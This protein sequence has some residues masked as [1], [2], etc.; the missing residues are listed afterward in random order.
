MFKKIL[1]SV[2]LLV[3][4]LCFAHKEKW[5]DNK[6]DWTPLMFAIYNGQTENFISIINAGAD[7]NYKIKT[8]FKL[9]AMHV[10]V[11]KN[12]DIAVNHL[13]ATRK[14]KNIQTYFE[15]SCGMNNIKTVEL[16]IKNGAHVNSPNGTFSNLMEACA[17]GS[18]EIVECLLKSGAKVNNYREVDG[19]T[20]LMLAALNG[21]PK[22]VKLLLK[23][24]A[25]KFQK[26]KNG[27]IAI[28]YVDQIYA[29]S[30]VSDTVKDELKVLLK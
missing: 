17:R 18:S 28:N 15:L 24:K 10:A 19:I 7:V 2:L 21:E 23:F 22:K 29:S 13:F 9:D 3:N 27:Q 11:L 26:D 8:S 5:D 30:K 14:F 1:L 16:F 4:L 6:E 20:A 25:N 12:N